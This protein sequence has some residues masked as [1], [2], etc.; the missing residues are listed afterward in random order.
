MNELP[1][2]VHDLLDRRVDPLDD[3]AARAWLL[4]HPEALEC[5]ATLR[6][7]LASLPHGPPR[8]VGRRRWPVPLVAGAVAA[9]AAVAFAFCA[10]ADAPTPLPR[11]ELV[12]DAVVAWRA[13]TREVGGVRSRK[14]TVEAACRSV[15][16][17]VLCLP[18]EHAR[19]VAARTTERALLL[20]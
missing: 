10:P 19:C 14:V 12:A 4:A 3:G 2:F 8:A 17:Q 18:T 7:Q 16:E 5:F 1:P 15:T 9:V 11:P 20:P 13:T 6:A